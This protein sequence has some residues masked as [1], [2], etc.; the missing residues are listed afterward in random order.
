MKLCIVSDIHTQPSREQCLSKWCVAPGSIVR[1][2][3]NELCGRPE[4]TGDD[5]H[6]HLFECRGM[7][8]AVD[9]LSRFLT[10]DC[11]GL[12]YSAGGTALWRTAAAGSAFRYLFCIS[13][14]RLRYEEAI[15]SPNHV[16][17]GEGDGNKPSQSWFSK[18]P[19]HATVFAQVS[20]DYYRHPDSPAALATWSQISRSAPPL[21]GGEST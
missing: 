10:P 8:D 9:A 4:L 3:L 13:S 19:Q 1:L 14:T 11:V 7:D 16:F 12:G 6:K 2:A 17:F 21:T 5:L 20:H 15:S 18:V